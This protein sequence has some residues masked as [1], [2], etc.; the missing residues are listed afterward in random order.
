MADI[1]DR[2]TGVLGQAADGLA[3]LATGTAT[4]NTAF[5]TLSGTLKLVPVVGDAAAKLTDGTLKYT[6]AVNDTA[7]A[8]GKYGA[9][10]M[11]NTGL[12]QEQTKN[13]RMSGEEYVKMMANNSTALSGFGKNMDQSAKRLLEMGQNIQ[14]ADPSGKLKAAGVSSADFTNLMQVTMS[15]RRTLD[16]QD[17]KSKKAA[18]E[19]TVQLAVEMEGIA[20]LTGKSREQQQ[21]DLAA[22]LAKAEVQAELL[23]LDD[24]AR[25]Q[26]MKMRTAVGPLGESIQGLADE[27]ATGGVRT[28]E[29]AAKMA[30]LGP[31]GADFEKAVLQMKEAKTKEE[32]EAAAAALEKAKIRVTEYQSSKEYLD[33]VKYDR[34]ATGDAARKQFQENATINN[35]LNMIR[36]K[37]IK[38]EQDLID[39]KDKAA[40]AGIK[41]VDLDTGKVEAGTNVGQGL[42]KA[43]QA[44]ESYT[45]VAGTELKKLADAA[46][47]AKVTLDA[48]AKLPMTKAQASDQA[49]EL[50][51]SMTGGKVPGVS[52][53]SMSVPYTPGAQP[54]VSRAEGSFGSVGKLIEDFGKGTPA[55]L[56]GKEGV[57][58]EKQL[59][60]LISQVK[61]SVTQGQST[62]KDSTPS[63]SA[64]PVDT[65]STKSASTSDT[66]T[67]NDLNT[68]LIQLNRMMG[69]LLSYS[70]QM[71]ENTQM[72]VKATKG[73]SGNRL[74]V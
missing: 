47:G 71:A 7:N 27:I 48:I 35:Q 41:G 36:D 52:A 15:N 24:N 39:A 40:K 64:T 55:I 69:Q 44:L 11:N 67:M 23:Q 4:V 16:V 51:K 43:Q 32:K 21:K 61:Q 8:A 19:N 14:E 29:G 70:E 74:A 57:I 34:T 60:S 17:E 68:Q 56:H 58:T 10:F 49:G 31:A 18:I 54:L 45:A 5:T 12:L 26:Y 50:I 59:N 38:T 6:V 22:G 62:I 25:N 28:K 20:K 13:A 30:A 2:F 65:P 66:A 42:N 72:Q 53:P 63:V 1:V 37:N 3:S 73:L 46:G 9:A 33:Q